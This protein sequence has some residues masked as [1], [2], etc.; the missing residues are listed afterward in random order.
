VGGAAL[1][2]GSGG[3]RAC[4][5]AGRRLA[6]GK[7]L[8]RSARLLPGAI[9]APRE[10]P[11]AATDQR[12]PG[13]QQP[14]AG[15][16]FRVPQHPRLRRLVWLL[17]RRL[18]RPAGR[19]LRLA[20][21]R[22]QLPGPTAAPLEL[23]DLGLGRPRPREAVHR[24]FQLDVRLAVR[25][26]RSVHGRRRPSSSDRHLRRCRAAGR[27]QAEDRRGLTGV[28]QLQLGPGGRSRR[29]HRRRLLR[30]RHGQLHLVADRER[31]PA[32]RKD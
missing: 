14:R 30:R 24:V 25:P 1:H 32:G 31:R 18:P 8:W 9:A 16:L 23:L 28:D 3:F 11:V 10:L 29:R 13:R 26:P 20:A 5:A 17:V 12:S 7:R 21:D 2:P 15:H 4:A 6:V 27:S 22:H 19:F